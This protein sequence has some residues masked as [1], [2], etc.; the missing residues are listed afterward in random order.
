M[1]TPAWM[2]KLLTYA[3]LS[4]AIKR[5]LGPEDRIALEF[6]DALRIASLEGRLLAVWVHPANELAGKATGTMVAVARAIGLIPG[7]PDYLFLAADRSL[8]IELKAGDGKQSEKQKLFQQWCE[9][10]G[11]PYHICRSADEALSILKTEGGFL[12]LGKGGF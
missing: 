5:R 3:P 11:V 1:S 6:T 9:L 10:C 2:A 12:V 8:A 4:A 7:C